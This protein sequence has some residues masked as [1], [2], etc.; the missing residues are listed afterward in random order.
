[1]L[2]TVTTTEISE[3]TTVSATSGGD[4]TSNG[5]GTVTARGVCWNTTSNPTLENNIGITINGIGTESYIS[6][7]TG[8]T[9]NTTYY[10]AAYATNEKGTSYGQIKSFLAKDY[11][12][13]PRDG[14]T[15]EIVIIGNQTWM[16]ENLNYQTTNSWWYDN[17]STNGDI[18]GM[19]YTWDAA[20]TAC[21]SGWH[22]PSDGEWKV[23]TDFLGGAYVAGGKMKEAGTVHW[24]APN[25]GATNSS[26][27]TALPG[28]YRDTSGLF[29]FLGPYGYWWSSTE[30]TSGLAWGRYMDYD[31]DQGDR[32]FDTKASGY[33]VRCIKN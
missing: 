16:A 22:L 32:G 19:L 1:M 17:S 18:Y 3:I 20:Q 27:F 9:E 29:Y 30:Y 2:P 21:P 12:I 15:Y 7:L 5:N 8:L 13:D 31:D 10:V 14:Q 26:G 4:V 6:L 33:N 25:T 28:G 11:L 24:N 23:L